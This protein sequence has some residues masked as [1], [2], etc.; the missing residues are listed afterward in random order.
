M[1]AKII[2]QQENSLFSRQELKVQLSFSGPIPSKADLIQVLASQLKVKPEVV[3]IKKIFSSFGDTTALALVKVYDSP[4]VIKKI[5]KPGS[6][7]KKA[8]QKTEAGPQPEKAQSKK[9]EGAKPE[10][11]EENKEEK[12]GD[13]SQ[14]AASPE[15]PSPKKTNEKSVKNG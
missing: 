9:G 4:E 12:K 13:K 2:N 5:E 15:K 14:T 11:K 3:I 8:K 1:K 10:S 6:K 7:A